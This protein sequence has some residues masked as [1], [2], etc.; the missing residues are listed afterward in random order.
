MY[1]SEHISRVMCT[2]MLF[3]KG[4][5][6]AVWFRY[7]H[8]D[9]EVYANPLEFRLDRFETQPKPNTDTPFGN[10][11]RVCP[12]KELAMAEMLIFMHRFLV[13]YDFEAT[14][15]LRTEQ[16]WTMPHPKDG[17]PLKIT[18]RANGEMGMSASIPLQT[19]H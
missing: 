5:T 17:L 6:I 18:K 12:G 15:D 11:N 13:T 14:G 19:D 4:W 16:Y 9:P 3:P 8:L 2:G 10:G 7:F 1:C